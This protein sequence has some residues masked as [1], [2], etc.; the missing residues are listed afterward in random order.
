MYKQALNEIYDIA[1]KYS[2]PQK[3]IEILKTNYIIFELKKLKEKYDAII[4][5]GR[6]GINTLQLLENYPNPSLMFLRPRKFGKTLFT[7][8]LENYYEMMYNN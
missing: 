2:V 3:D 7:S 4:I 8:T 1:Q 6:V 5:D